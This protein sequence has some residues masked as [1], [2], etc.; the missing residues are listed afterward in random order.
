MEALKRVEEGRQA[1]SYGGKGMHGKATAERAD[2]RSLIA[3]ASVDPSGG[4]LG[5]ADGCRCPVQAFQPRADKLQSSGLL[6]RPIL[7][8]IV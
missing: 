5:M 3:T 6:P 2:G 4:S 8:R 7:Q 1:S